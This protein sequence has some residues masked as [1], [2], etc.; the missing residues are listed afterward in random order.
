[1]L[2]RMLDDPME[3]GVEA[4]GSAAPVAAASAETV[5]PTNEDPTPDAAAA[6]QLT[7]G[8]VRTGASDDRWMVA[9]GCDE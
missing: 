3:S 1:M 2:E 4:S 6:G 7:P 9:P 8:Q 5:E